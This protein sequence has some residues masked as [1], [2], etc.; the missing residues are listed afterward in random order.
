MISNILLAAAVA[1]PVTPLCAPVLAENITSPKTSPVTVP[2]AAFGALGSS[3]GGESMPPTMALYETNVSNNIACRNAARSK[4]FE[5]GARDLSS[6]DSNSQWATIG[7]MR[8][9]VWCRDT[10]AII[11]V[12]G[13][14]YN[15]V[16][17]ARD[18][19]VKAF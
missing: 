12:T 10:R 11:S 17:E 5:L 15:S 3:D 19:I 13:Y 18:A 7:N 14:N 16:V 9:V 4:Y 1:I 2:T 6:S 8:A